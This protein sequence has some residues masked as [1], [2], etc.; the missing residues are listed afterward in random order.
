MIVLGRFGGTYESAKTDERNE[1]NRMITYL[2]NQKQ[3]ISFV[4]VYSLDRFSRTGDNAIYISS[5]LKKQGISIIAVTQPID[6]S[7]VSGVLQQ[8]IQFIFSKYDNDLRREKCVT[9]MKEKLLRGEWIGIAPIGYEYISTGRNKNQSIGISDKGKLLKKAF[10]WKLNEDIGNIEI[11]KRL[12]KLGLPISHKQLTKTLRNPFY[13]GY[14]C[15]K[16]LEGVLVKGKHPALISEE[17]F[18]RVNNLM[19]EKYTG[20]KWSKDDEKTPMKRFIICEECGAPFTGYVKNKKLK[21]GETAI[22]HY[23][24]CRTTGCKV[25]KSA[26]KTHANFEKVLESLQINPLLKD[27]IRE[28]LEIQYYEL[29]SSDI[30]TQKILKL[31]SS[32]LNSKLETL[33]ERFA[34]G[35]IDRGLYDKLSAKLKS[36]ITSISTE[37]EKTA[38]KISNPT[39]IFEKIVSIASQ[40]KTLWIDSDLENKKI[41]QNI[42]FPDKIIYNGENDLFRTNNV[43]VL[44]DLSKKI[45]D[46]YDVSKQ[47]MP[48]KISGHS[49]SVERKRFELSVQLP[50]HTLSRRAP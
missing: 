14:I 29:A 42:I 23:Y 50:A 20:N 10:Q 22:L 6:V 43:N 40:L 25:N 30:E 47:K 27:I 38:L 37:I 35:E 12:T 36:E 19:N 46:S 11:A 3:K 13:C 44:I 8:N 26:S 31:K 4:L 18:L 16:L 2:K 17:T 39:V 7:T 33:E 5:Q 9:G 1:F 15:S 24:K 32:E 21:N 41:L 49:P 34:Y 48:T 45:S 28:E